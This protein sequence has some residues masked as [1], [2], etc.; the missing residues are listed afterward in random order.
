VLKTQICVTRPQCAKMDLEDVEW[1]CEL[2]DGDRWR[3]LVNAVLD[4]GVPQN[5]GDFLSS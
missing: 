5:V 3:A 1:G 2:E 4:L